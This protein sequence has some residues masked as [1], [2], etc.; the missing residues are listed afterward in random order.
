MSQRQFL[1]SCAE[2]MA[3]TYLEQNELSLIQ[4]NY[5]CY[6]GEIDLIMQDK[7]DI[8]FVEVR[9]RSES[10]YG[11]AIESIGSSKIRKLIKTATHYLQKR[12]LLNHRNSRFDIVTIDFLSEVPQIDW[13]KNA[14]WDRG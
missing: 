7:E 2:Q 9:S 4:Q 12:D 13:I 1:G 8:V 11:K 5:R 10:G 3:R 14:F 6:H